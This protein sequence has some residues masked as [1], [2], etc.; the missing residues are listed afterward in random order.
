MEEQQVAKLALIK[1]I[2]Y[3]KREDEDPEELMIG[4]LEKEA[5][6][7][8]VE[9]GESYWFLSYFCSSCRCVIP[10]HMLR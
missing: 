10:Q 1:E 5:N 2:Q 3:R 6:V 4:S 8:Q 9:V 7:E